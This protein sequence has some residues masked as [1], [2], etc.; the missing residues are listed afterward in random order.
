MGTLL[1]CSGEWGVRVGRIT[2]MGRI[3]DDCT[4]SE[5]GGGGLCGLIGSSEPCTVCH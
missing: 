5:V 4:E 2:R 1:E 3:R